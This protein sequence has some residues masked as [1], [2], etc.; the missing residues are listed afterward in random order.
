MRKRVKSASGFVAA[1]S[2]SSPLQ[3]ED[4]PDYMKG[5]VSV[6][7]ST[8]ADTANANL[9]ALNAAMFDLYDSAAQTFTK[10]ILA[11]HPVILALF[12]GAD[13]NFTRFLGM[14]STKC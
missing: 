3:A 13:G 12:S 5:L 1:T 8:P 2:L 14:C 11:I 4:L 7:E 10:N 6:R 9:L